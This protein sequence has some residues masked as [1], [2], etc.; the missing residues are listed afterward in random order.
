MVHQIRA[1]T[2]NSGTGIAE[3]VWLAFWFPSALIG[4]LFHIVP[5]GITRGIAKRIQDGATTTALSRLGIEVAEAEAEIGT[6]VVE[7]QPES[8]HP[9]PPS[10]YV[11]PGP[12]RSGVG[13]PARGSMRTA[14]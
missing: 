6:V 13:V 8:E 14:K 2:A 7:P 9:W 3:A 10:G 1:I 11:L 12:A 4:T 5:F